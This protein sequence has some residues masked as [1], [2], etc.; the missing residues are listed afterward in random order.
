MRTRSRVLELP[1]GVRLATTGTTLTTLLPPP[2]RTLLMPS[3]RRRVMLPLL[4]REPRPS[5]LSSNPLRSPRC[6]FPF[7]FA[8]TRRKT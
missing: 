2:T 5:L 8:A 4:L 7:L 3:R 1:T 6:V